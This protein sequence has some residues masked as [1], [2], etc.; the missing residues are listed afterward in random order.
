MPCS[1]LTKNGSIV[2]SM[3]S[4]DISGRNISSLLKGAIW[5]LWNSVARQR[6]TTTLRPTNQDQKQTLLLV[7][8]LFADSIVLLSETRRVPRSMKG[9]LMGG[10]TLYSERKSKVIFLLK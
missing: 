4:P 5:P 6:T 7:D 9:L 2:T 8:V 3:I 10:K 1:R